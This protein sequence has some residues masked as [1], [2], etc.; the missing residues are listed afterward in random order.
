MV[1]ITHQNKEQEPT[2]STSNSEKMEIDKYWKSKKENFEKL[3]KNKM[4]KFD[5]SVQISL[6]N[7][8]M[9]HRNIES[10][11]KNGTEQIQTEINDQNYIIKDITNETIRIILQYLIKPPQGNN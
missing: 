9:A 1:I 4:D 6:Q 5:E 2:D 8:N 11:L 3:Y 7:V 10:T